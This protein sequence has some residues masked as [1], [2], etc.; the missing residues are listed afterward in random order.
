M[1]GRSILC[2]ALLVC[3]LSAE[4]GLAQVQL[5]PADR[6]AFDTQE[7]TGE[8]DKYGRPRVS[9][10][11]LQRMKYVALEEAWGTVREAGYH[12]KF[13]GDWLII[14]P[15]RPIVGRALTAAFLPS[16]PELER[17]MLDAARKQGLRGAMNQFPI[18]MLAQGDVY[19]ADGFGK[20]K[21]GTLIGNN[22]AQ[23][24]Y[25]NS[26]NG[27]IFYGSARDLAGMREIEGFNAFVK[28]WHP[29]YIQE[30]MLASIN[31]PIRIGEAV[32]LPGDVVLALEGGVL[33]IPPHLAERVVRRSEVA[34][35]TDA[36]R[37][38][39]IREGRYTLEETYGTQ[40]T[41]AI[42]DDF[43]NWLSTDRQRLH[44]DLGVGFTTIDEMIKTRSRN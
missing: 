42:N 35:L 20:I 29:S 39:R 9:D 17:R 19:V 3:G 38:Q 16:S 8:R 34:R 25:T 40:W 4:H 2:G 7:W 32:V 23:A 11:I 28:G 41:A 21:D 6:I 10:D 1:T 18:Y 33:F 12:N 26:G 22:L 13:E 43:Y 30:M 14:H 5:V 37:I 36:F 44:D 27:P 31:A 15:D 24:I